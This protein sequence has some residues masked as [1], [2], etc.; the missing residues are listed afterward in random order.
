ME[1]KMIVTVRLILMGQYS[2]LL[3][4]FQGLRRQPGNESSPHAYRGQ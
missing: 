1:L 3:V 2:S 4:P